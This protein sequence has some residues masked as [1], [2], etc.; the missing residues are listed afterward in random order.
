[1]NIRKLSMIWRAI[2]EVEGTKGYT[3]RKVF[4]VITKRVGRAGQGHWNNVG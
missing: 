1:M 3:R 2:I 4:K